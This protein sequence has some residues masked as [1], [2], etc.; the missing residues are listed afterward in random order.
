MSKNKITEEH[1]KDDSVYYSNEANWQY[2]SVS[3][4]KDFIACESCALAK[5]KGDWDAISNPL[6]L[7]VGN[8]VHSYFE[9]EE[10]HEQFIRDNAGSIT[11][12]P[13]VADLKKELDK[14]GLDYKKSATKPELIKSFEG[15]PLPI[16]GLLND[17]TKA[18]KYIEKVE[19]DPLF[20]LLWQ[21]EK[22]TVITGELFGETWKGKIDLLNIEQG[23]FI[24]L[25]T[26]AKMNQKYW[27]TTYGGW[28]SFVDQYRYGLQLAVYERLLEQRYG[29]PFTGYIFAVSKEDI[30]DIAAIDIIDVKKEFEMDLL[31]Q[32]IEQV[33]EVKTGQKEPEPCGTCDYCKTYKQ[34]DGF[35][36]S[37]ELID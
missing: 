35:V 34:L 27:S 8:Y 2:L 32:T 36:Y 15:N 31:Q 16:G 21:G 12:D 17:F 26:T 7:L 9:S 3:Q 24:D 28:V 13:T 1:L 20:Q 37:D 6:P 11:K 10:A 4:Y 33:I 14:L 22:E 5:L 23:Y 30:P 18:N 19:N 29:K 25:K